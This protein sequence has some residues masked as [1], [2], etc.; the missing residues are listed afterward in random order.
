ML[1][2]ATLLTG[3]MLQDDEFDM[4]GSENDGNKGRVSTSLSTVLNPLSWEIVYR[5]DGCFCA[6]WYNN[7]D[8]EIANK[9]GD[10][11]G[12]LMPHFDRGT[13]RLD[14]S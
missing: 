7:T 8:L 5:K 11:R 1:C 4:V 14:Q 6:I 13:W 9:H 3:M 12:V 2:S 10:S